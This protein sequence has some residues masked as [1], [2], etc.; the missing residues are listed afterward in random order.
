MR[1]RWEVGLNESPRIGR[2]EIS[3]S[4]VAASV[5]FEGWIFLQAGQISLDTIRPVDCGCVSLYVTFLTFIREF[6]DNNEE[7]DKHPLQK[8]PMHSVLEDHPSC[9]GRGWVVAQSVPTF[10]ARSPRIHLL[11]S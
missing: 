11:H 10:S 8:Q 3:I 4:R 1:R 9:A 2:G 5:V 6:A 7:L